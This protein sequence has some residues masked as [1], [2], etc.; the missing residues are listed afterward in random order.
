[1]KRNR[2][3][4]VRFLLPALTLILLGFGA[5]AKSADPCDVSMLPQEVQTRLTKDYPDWQPERLENLY[6]EDRQLWTKAHP[7]DC[8]GIAIGHFE[9]KTEL[10]YALL[11]ISKPSRERSGF[12]VIVFS[13]TGPSA[14]FMAHVATK[15]NIGSYD[16]GSDE[17]I[18][19]VPPGHYEEA[20]GP[21]NVNTELDSILSETIGKG[22]AVYYWKKGRY[23]ELIT[24]E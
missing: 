18:A 2:S 11:L 24:S 16:K 15:W 8:P 17:V 7:N 22:A 9:S 6:E 5:Q 23:H 20:M 19:T 10:S 12:R 3:I 13:H 4:H 1:M 21:R 14:P